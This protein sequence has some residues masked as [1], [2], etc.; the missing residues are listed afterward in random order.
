MDSLQLS[1]VTLFQESLH[2]RI[3]PTKYKGKLLL[4]LATNP[5]TRWSV[6]KK[7][8]HQESLLIEREI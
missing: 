5:T 2:R 1:Y 7:N 4:V 6:D 8:T 3:N